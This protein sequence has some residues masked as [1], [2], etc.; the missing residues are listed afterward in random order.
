MTKKEIK[1]NTILIGLFYI[2]SSVNMLIAWMFFEASGTWLWLSL[3]LLVASA[4]VV[5]DKRESNKG[6][7]WVWNSAFC[8]LMVTVYGM[9]FDMVQGFESVWTVIYLLELAIC[10]CVWRAKW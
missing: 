2:F 10:I 5:L 4:V 3:V 8:H 6:N 7:F 9:V 1:R